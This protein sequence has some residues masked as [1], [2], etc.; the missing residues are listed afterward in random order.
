MVFLSTVLD[1]KFA[2]T[3]NYCANKLV[4]VRNL[5]ENSKFGLN[6]HNVHS[7]RFNDKNSIERQEQSS[8]PN[9]LDYS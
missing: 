1:F 3:L 7:V 9:N 6:N 8:S 5:Y 4:R 2:G